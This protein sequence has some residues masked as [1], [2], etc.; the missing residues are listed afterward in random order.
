MNVSMNALY[1]VASTTPF[2]ALGGAAASNGMISSSVTSDTTFFIPQWEGLDTAPKDIVCFVGSA[3][4]L[5]PEVRSIFGGWGWG[6]KGDCAVDNGCGT[7]IFTG[8]GCNGAEEIGEHWYNT[9]TLDGADPWNV[10]GYR[11]TDEE[12]YGKYASCVH[13]GFEDLMSNPQQIVGHAFVI[14]GEDGTP[15]SCGVISA[16]PA[17]FVGPTLLNTTTVPIPGLVGEAL[18]GST[19]KAVMSRLEMGDGGESSSGSGSEEDAEEDAAMSAY[20]LNPEATGFV[21]VMA[22][23]QENIPDSVC[24]LGYATGLSPNVESFLLDTGS[25]QCDTK[26]GCGTHIHEGPSCAT[27]DRQ[28][29]HYYD[30]VELA[31]DPWQREAYLSTGSA[32]ETVMIG[33]VIT[34]SGATGFAD[35]RVFLLHDH[36]GDRVLCGL[37]EGEGGDDNDN[38]NNGGG[39]ASSTTVTSSNGGESSSSS[40]EEEFLPGSSD[41]EKGAT[42]SGSSNSNS[43]AEEEE[44][45]N[46]S[47]DELIT[48]ESDV[49]SFFGSFFSN[50]EEVVDDGSSPSSREE[51]LTMEDTICSTEYADIFSTMCAFLQQADL[52]DIFA[53]KTLTAFVPTNDAFNRYPP[54]ASLNNHRWTHFNDTMEANYLASVSQGFLY[55]L[56]SFHF[57]K[58]LIL[59]TDQLGCSTRHQMA[60]NQ[61]SRTRCEGSPIPHS[62]FQKG[63][64]NQDLTN[65]PKLL[66]GS[67]SNIGTC[68]GIIHPISQVMLSQK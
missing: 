23:V 19:T 33:C 5:E 17:D 22:T 12:G 31:E 15:V 14:H 30:E 59:P 40:D 54:T 41:E 20:T 4:P 55:E 11:E 37:L 42:P 10:V 16:A 27:K 51:C 7:H 21:T 18:S 9:E 47:S 61:Y 53:T 50:R 32:G 45:S 6:W 26:N 67:N 34:G 57:I 56:L 39:D 38:G 65:L 63:K 36:L 24:Y 35:S 8:T 1:Y 2:S 68:N 44:G 49:G 52:K 46:S 25:Q 13:T 28:G 58:D 62:R 3:S 66:G 48:H 60:N 43:D 29:S 64:G